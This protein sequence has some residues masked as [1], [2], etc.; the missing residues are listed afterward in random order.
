MGQPSSF[1]HCQQVPLTKVLAPSSETDR[2]VIVDSISVKTS[3]GF[4]RR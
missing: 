3:V 1:S 4:P 2:A